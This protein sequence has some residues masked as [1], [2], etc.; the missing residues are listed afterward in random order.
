MK[1][2]L[3]LSNYETIYNLL[4][5]LKYMFYTESSIKVFL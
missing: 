4:F 5:I 2:L 3:K 1:Y